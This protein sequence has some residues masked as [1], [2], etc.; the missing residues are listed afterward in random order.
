MTDLNCPACGSRGRKVKPLTIESLAAPAALAELETTEG[1]AHCP[2]SGCDAV[3]FHADT[4]QALGRADC[5]VRV[6]MKETEPPRPVCYCFGHTIEEIEA[7][8]R[9]TGK[10]GIPA[11]IADKCRQGLDRCEETNPQGS[12]CLGNINQVVKAAAPTPA[13]EPFATIET[14][15]CCNP[16]TGGCDNG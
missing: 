6:G 5:R 7:E 15:D 3:W 10:T 14:S 9:A 4:G 11:S 2:A 8:I 1:F 16:H 12:C 13:A